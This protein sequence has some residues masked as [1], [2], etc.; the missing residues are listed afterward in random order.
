MNKETISA[1][2]TGV[3]AGILLFTLKMT[4]LPSILYKY[5]GTGALISVIVVITLNVLFL[6]LV[7]WVKQ[8]YSNISMYDLLKAKLGTFITKILYIL[9]FSFFFL[10]LLLMIGDSYSFLKDVAD[11][12]ISLITV[13]ICFLPI[14]ATLAYSGIRN[15]GRTSEFFLPF[16]ILSLV[17]AVAFSIVPI[18]SFDFGSL[19]KDGFGGFFNSIFRTSFWTGDLFAILIFLDKIDIKKGKLKN[20]FFPLITM[21]VVFVGLYVLYFIL[22]QEISIFH[23]NIIYD[24]VQYAIGTSKGWHMDFFAIVVFM[25]NIYLQGAI[26]LYCANECLKKTIKFDCNGVTLSAIII[27][28]VATDFLY[29]TDYLSYIAFA[30]NVLCYFSAI[31]ILFVPLVLIIIVLTKKG[32][33]D[34]RT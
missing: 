4:S 10:K 8:K 29:L 15:I 18:T 1:H 9:F 31:T 34:E 26:L 27:A 20:M 14:I 22:Y 23:V 25:I 7:V 19:T 21:A 33:S 2:Q 16:I 30:E 3:L 13:L 5:N 11:E 32:K 6:W 17:T 28:L 24:V 12:E